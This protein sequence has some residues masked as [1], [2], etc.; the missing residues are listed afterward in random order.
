MENSIFLC[1]LPISH[2][3]SHPCRQFCPKFR[4]EHF[5]VHLDL[6]EGSLGKLP[7]KLPTLLPYP[8]NG[9]LFRHRSCQNSRNYTKYFLLHRSGRNPHAVGKQCGKRFPEGYEQ[10]FHTLL[11][12]HVEKWIFRLSTGQIRRKTKGKWGEPV[13]FRR[14][15][16]SNPQPSH[17]PLCSFHKLL[18]THVEKCVYLAQGAKPFWKRG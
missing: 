16:T 9:P 2:F 17:T 10:V 11:R 13:V 6:S 4:R 8:T 5:F 12:T 15:S 14:S 3:H 1:N 18:K 7:C